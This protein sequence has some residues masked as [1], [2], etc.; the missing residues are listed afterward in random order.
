MPI[1]IPSSG[2]P[3]S[4]ERLDEFCKSSSGAPPYWP[5]RS[6][7]LWALFDCL[8]ALSFDYPEFQ[9]WVY[10]ELRPHIGDRPTPSSSVERNDLRGLSASYSLYLLLIQLRK[11]HRL[12]NLETRSQVRRLIGFW[13]LCQYLEDW[14]PANTAIASVRKIV[15]SKLGSN[16][17]VGALER[18]LQKAKKRLQ[19]AIAL[20]PGRSFEI[21]LMGT[22][23]AK[24]G[25]IAVQTKSHEFNTDLQRH[26]A[27]HLRDASSNRVRAMPGKDALSLNSLRYAGQDLRLRVKA[28][29]CMAIAACLQVITRLPARLLKGLPL[30]SHSGAGRFLAHL[31]LNLGRYVFDLKMV[32]DLSDVPT[33]TSDHLC[34]KT[35]LGSINLPQFLCKSLRAFVKRRPEE[36]YLGDIVQFDLPNPRSTLV[37]SHGHRITLSRIQS[38]LPTLLIQKGAHRWPTAVATQSWWLVSKGRRA[39][40]VCPQHRINAL[41]KVSYEHLGW[42][43]GTDS[44][45]QDKFVGSALTP[46]PES[47]KTI[48]EFLRSTC[49]K[50]DRV[51]DS[52][53]LNKWAAFCSFLAAWFLALRAR[54]RYPVDWIAAANEQC[55]E[56]NDKDIHLEAP[57]PVPVIAQM[58]AVLMTWNAVV[59]A[60]IA[61]AKRDRTI[62]S[63]LCEQIESLCKNGAFPLFS[64]DG[65]STIRFAG[66]DTWLRHLPAQFRPARNFGRH[67]WPWRLM[68]RGVFQRQ[69]DVLMRHQTTYLVP[70][71]SKQIASYEVD[72]A[73]LRT[74]MEAEVLETLGSDFLDAIREDAGND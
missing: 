3:W 41:T 7:A 44:N 73:A 9:R 16:D 30:Q 36:R 50:T 33:A 63:A 45:D 11:P 22:D 59:A 35:S 66:T 4:A 40:S 38:T 13:A 10:A 6:E 31:D 69:V 57:A 21:G 42:G 46:R 72:V 8:E 27:T 26:W 54:E 20:N 74:A 68:E 34:V 71:G 5:H 14:S 62:P 18:Y 49:E 64:V 56:I 43:Q 28:G 48:A 19:N 12:S 58:R 55:I 51:R 15:S 17:Y 52:E 1:L 23:F 60:F 2:A 53:Q 25:A 24:S 47:L 65:I 39:Y 32:V 29:D 70:Y 61:N 67:F 37:Q